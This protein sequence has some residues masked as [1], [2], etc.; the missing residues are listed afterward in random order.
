MK[1]EFEKKELENAEKIQKYLDAGEQVPLFVNSTEREYALRFKCI[2]IA[3]ANA[4]LFF[5]MSNTKD[6]N[7]KLSDCGIEILSIDYRDTKN[8][9]IEVLEETIRRVKEM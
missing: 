3:K 6:T 2:D 8:D 4:L 5:L 7:T 1:L 9:I